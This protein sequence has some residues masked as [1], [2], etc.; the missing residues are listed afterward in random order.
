MNLLESGLDIE[1]D[2]DWK[3]Y[4]RVPGTDPKE[5]KDKA[6]GIL[7]HIANDLLAYEL[8]LS[9][10]IR[11]M[12]GI[13]ASLLHSATITALRALPYP[14]NLVR[15]ITHSYL[16][17]HI[18]RNIPK[19]IQ[20]IKETG[21]IIREMEEPP[22]DFDWKRTLLD[23]PT[24]TKVLNQLTTKY[25]DLAIK[26]TQIPRDQPFGVHLELMLAV[27]GGFLLTAYATWV[28]TSR[29][30][31]SITRKIIDSYFLWYMTTFPP[32]SEAKEYRP[33]KSKKRPPQKWRRKQKF[34]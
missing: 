20:K 32:L 1:E 29:M 28:R 27:A 34:R 18:Q 22:V 33:K 15:R 17:D 26:T 12:I 6:E 31:L 3:Y 10:T 13:S 2:L 16:Y 7:H 11:I 23:A 5:L 21:V 14:L 8:G 24:D 4:L 9:G 25:L 30:P 19:L